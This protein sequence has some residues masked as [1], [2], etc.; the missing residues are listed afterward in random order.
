[1]RPSGQGG[2]VNTNFKVVKLLGKGSYGTVFQVQRISD[3]KT[4]ALKE[5][6][7]R[8]MNQAER[9]DAANEIRL[10]ASVQVRP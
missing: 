5:M 7:V 6:D 2:G 8:A 3:N 1:M 4:Y 10:L 9:E